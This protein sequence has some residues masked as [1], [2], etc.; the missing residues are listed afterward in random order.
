[1][2]LVGITRSDGRVIDVADMSWR[3]DRTFRPGEPGAT[4]ENL[5]HLLDRDSTGTYTLV[6]RV[7]DKTARC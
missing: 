4:N 1:M 5:L 6:F 2:E 3:T 7:V